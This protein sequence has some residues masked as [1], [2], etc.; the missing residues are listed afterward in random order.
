MD[1]I[2]NLHRGKSITKKACFYLR[3]YIYRDNTILKT[4]N[5]VDEVYQ[6]I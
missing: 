1:K 2:N 6:T 3:K 4:P 5:F